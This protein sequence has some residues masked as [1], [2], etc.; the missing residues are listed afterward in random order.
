MLIKLL[1]YNLKSFIKNRFR[2]FI[3]LL[4]GLTVAT[5]CFE[6]FWFQTLSSY[7]DELINS[8]WFNRQIIVEFDKNQ[9][10]DSYRVI[11]N[12][13]NSNIEMIDRAVLHNKAAYEND[14]SRDING[15]KIGTVGVFTTTPNAYIGVGRGFT[16]DDN[17]KDNILSSPGINPHPKTNEIKVNG[18]T[19]TSI[20]TIRLLDINY[21]IVLPYE[22]FKSLNNNIK[23]ITIVFKNI[24]DN[25]TISSIYNDFKSIDNTA[26]ITR[27]VE[28]NV[29]FWDFFKDNMLIGL[30]IVVFSLISVMTLYK[31][32][33]I[34][35]TYTYSVYKLCGIKNS[36]LKLLIIL[37]VFIYS[38]LAF[39][40]GTGLYSFIKKQNIV[41]LSH[42]ESIFE[43][44]VFYLLLVIMT[45]IFVLPLLRKLSKQS[46]IEDIRS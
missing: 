2:I 7:E 12:I 46:P 27:P 11:D 32:W 36:I 31:Y 44:L 18:R 6:F 45:L 40:I 19:Y 25:S 16:E 37:E 22:R 4:L 43:Y 41:N 3:I 23:Q 28:Q 21:S 34:L 5:F 42:T 35:N 30:V 1:F 8:P 24:P 33:I 29:L 15:S 20:G 39:A 38:T 26:T 13:I 17:T 9:K 14:K 10:A